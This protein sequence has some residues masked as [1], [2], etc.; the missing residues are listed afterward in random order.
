MANDCSNK[1][2]V[3]EL[4]ERPEKF[5]KLLETALY[6]RVLLEGEYYPVRVVEGHLNEFR[7]KSKWNPPV[8][9]LTA[10]SAELEGETLLLEY[11][12]WESGFRGQA[13]IKNGGVVENIHRK[14]YCGPACLFADMTHPLADL[15][16]PY[17]RPRTLAEDAARQLQDAIG[18]VRQLKETLEDERFADSRSRAYGNPQTVK[19]TQAQLATM[20]EDM[21]EHAARISFESVLVEEPATV[22][23][24]TREDEGVLR[25]KWILSR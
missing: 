15:F 9:R 8:D 21:T 11:S 5:A 12:C 18:I 10:L 7:F 24:L 4:K 17:L 16:W 2:I 14:G 23:R 6:G 1:L 19:K 22:K 25:V 3:A 20:L 13:V